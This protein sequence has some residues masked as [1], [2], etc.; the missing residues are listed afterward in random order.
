MKH[1]FRRAGIAGCLFLA[2]VLAVKAQ[3]PFDVAAYKSYL[4]SHASATGSSVRAEYPAP[5]FQKR[6]AAATPRYLDSVLIKY[7]LTDD[8]R[9]LLDRNG[10]LVTERL[11]FDSFGDAY[12]DAWVKDMPVFVTSDAILHAVHM[13]YDEIL[14]ATEM[15]YL[16]PRLE[17]LL[18]AL[19][20][21]ALPGL[22]SSYTGMDGMRAP[23]RDVDLY[24]TVA[25]RLLLGT[26]VAPFYPE[27]KTPVSDILTRI[28]ALAPADVTLFSGTPRT[29]DFSQFTIRGH[30]TRSMQLGRYFRS[31]IWLGRTEFMLTKPVEQGPFTP[32]DEDIQRQIIASYLVRE[33]LDRGTSLATLNEIDDFLAFLVGES[34]NVGA[35]QLDELQNETGF[36]SAASLLDM[37][38]V[39][40]LQAVLATKPFAGQ[41]INSQILMSDPFA[42]EQIAPP[43]A[44]LLLGQRFI[45]DSY[46]FGNVVYDK[47]LKDGQK[48]RRML[49]KPLDALFALGN[50]AAAQFLQDDMAR[51]HYAPNLTSLRYLIDAYDASFW[52]SSLYNTWLDAVRALNPP[53][54]LE[55]LPPF[56]HT[57]AWWQQKMNTQLA[58]WAQ[59]RHDNILYA[60]QSYSG[61]VTCSFPEGYVE[62]YPALYSR[63]AVFARN[64][65]AL[66]RTKKLDYIAQYFKR[67]QGTMDTLRVIA[68]KELAGTPLLEGEY[69]FIQSM[70]FRVM[71]GCAPAY[72]GWY[73]KLFFQRDITDHDFIVA[74]VHTA[75]TDEAG[76][77]VGWVLHAGTGKVNLGFAV[78]PSQ[79]GGTVVYT[80]AMM[81]YHEHTTTN[82][83]RLDDEQWSESIRRSEYTRPDWVNIYLAD[84]HGSGR[85]PGPSLET[86]VT[87]MKDVPGIAISPLIHTV[88]P[89]PV[90]AAG[91]VISFHVPT[92]AAGP[93]RLEV[94]D[95]QGRRVR[96]LFDGETNAGYY[97]LHW[98]GRD[99]MH[100]PLP[101]GL[102]L[103]RLTAG[104]ATDSRRVSIVR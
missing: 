97:S 69:T 24:L 49:P 25:R 19:H 60:K 79:N 84:A 78:A 55:G 102:Y 16:I 23:L 83:K 54:S 61:G 29:L 9:D 46:V 12:G 37:N 76:N 67:M 27:N 11:S 8:E 18:A 10:F 53:A 99:D 90:P 101:A 7:R 86:S 26:D 1:V 15:Q 62:P 21:Q 2:A 72:D 95:L 3:A 66:Y 47:I 30:Y 48:V 22:E 40:S 41:R 98:N 77:P 57:A 6:A 38:V 28:E 51:F 75:P 82:F 65:E 56:M 17:S 33:A 89:S 63:L 88:Y 85:V 70:L 64:A 43:S 96:S 100:T 71:R 80:G 45:I 68:E 81:S 92:S 74:D 5:L 104:G 42:P 35:A 44:F 91:S 52:T 20:T 32:T 59:L 93:A 34:D 36:S 58:S 13:S 103:L 50:D 39:R 4:A 73:Q 31:M 87:G 14:I 94:F